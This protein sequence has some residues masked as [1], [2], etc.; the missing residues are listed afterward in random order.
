MVLFNKSAPSPDFLCTSSGI[1]LEKK[2]CTFADGKT[3][4]V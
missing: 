2:I 1:A 3:G 4:P